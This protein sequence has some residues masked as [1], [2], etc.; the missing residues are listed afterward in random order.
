MVRMFIGAMS[1]DQES[2]EAHL[3]LG[4]VDYDQLIEDIFSSDRVVS[5]W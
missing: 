5:W 3:Y 4:D 2:V 1:H